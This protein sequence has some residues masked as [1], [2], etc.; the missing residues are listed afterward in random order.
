MTIRFFYRGDNDQ[1]SNR[2]DH[3][4]RLLYDGILPTTGSRRHI[5]IIWT[6]R[7]FFLN[8]Q[9]NFSDLAGFV[10]DPVFALDNASTFRP[11]FG[12]G[13]Y[14]VNDKFHLGLSVPNLV[15]QKFN[16]FSFQE[17]S[18]IQ[19]F[20]YIDTGYGFSL[21]SDLVLDLSTLIKI[22]PGLP[23]QFDIN[24]VLGFRN[25]LW[26]GTSYRSFESFDVL[27]RVKLG[28]DYYI[29]YS[30]D[31]AAGSITLSRVDTR[32]HEFHLQFGISELTRKMNL[33][34]RFRR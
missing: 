34:K 15:E 31:I 8:D 5:H 19:R 32:S 4:N 17:G 20:T 21:K 10:D 6:T 18:D 16:L 24:G 30:Y 29:S 23:A 14:I 22:Q 28:R 11:N 1:R 13:I 25:F 9:T 7:R 12:A 3:T 2:S 33:K 27:F 26:L